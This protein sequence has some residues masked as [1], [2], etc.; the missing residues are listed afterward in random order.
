MSTRITNAVLPTQKKRGLR[1]GQMT[2][3]LQPLR[4][5]FSKSSKKNDDPRRERRRLFFYLSL[6]Y[7]KQDHRNEKIAQP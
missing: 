6:S 5:G 3:V 4:D 2:H 7:G 1:G